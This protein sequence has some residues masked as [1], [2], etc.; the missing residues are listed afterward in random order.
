MKQTSRITIALIVVLV[1]TCA[2]FACLALTVRQAPVETAPIEATPS[3]GKFGT[4]VGDETPFTP[5]W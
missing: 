3:N 2:G 5:E 4:V 1:V